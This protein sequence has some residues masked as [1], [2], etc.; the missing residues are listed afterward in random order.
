MQNRIEGGAGLF[1]FLSLY[2]SS[3][4]HLFYSLTLLSCRGDRAPQPPL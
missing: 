2:F 1:F 3:F 4:L